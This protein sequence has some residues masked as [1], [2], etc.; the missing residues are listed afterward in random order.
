MFFRDLRIVVCHWL[1]PAQRAAGIDS[2][3]AQRSE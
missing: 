1:L 3:Q 2:I